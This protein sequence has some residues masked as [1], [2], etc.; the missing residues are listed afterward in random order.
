[1]M[2][3][4]MCFL[5]YLILFIVFQILYNFCNVP[6]EF[7][8]DMDQKYNNNNDDDDDNVIYFFIYS[9]NKLITINPSNYM[10]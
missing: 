1:M 9:S 8:F 10:E 5:Y 3:C 2:I 6:W 4:I 7:H